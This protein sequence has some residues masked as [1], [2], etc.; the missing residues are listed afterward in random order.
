MPS[1]I[2]F[3][4]S[5]A[6][7]QSSTSIYSRPQKKQKMSITQTYFLAHSARGKLSKEASRSDHDLRLLV[8]HANLLD[9]LMMDLA[10]AEQEQERWFNK[11]VS[12]AKATDE[13]MPSHEWAE[14]IIEEPGADWEVED[15]DS[16]DEESQYDEDEDTKMT[17]STVITTTE[18]DQEDAEE[19]EEE[20][21]GE[22]ALTRT[23]SRH[24]PPELSADSD[25]DSEDEHMPPSPPQPTFDSFTEKERQAI[26]TTSFYD[27]KEAAL[28]ATEQETFAQEGFYLPSRQQPTMIAAY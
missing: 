7:K 16:T 13:E 14:T 25:S 17:S 3:T 4:P 12:G 15:A 5:A 10:S 24:T 21:Y 6:S 8:G 1:S 23:P 27:K 11:S 28:T 2:S 19:D 20:V 26:A 22:L 18:I 9:S